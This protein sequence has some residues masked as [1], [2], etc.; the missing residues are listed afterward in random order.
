MLFR[1]Y[2][3]PGLLFAASCLSHASAGDSRAEIVE[4]VGA[5]IK[6]LASDELQGRGVETKGIELAAQHILA[7][8][9][10]FGLKPGMPD[11]TY[12]QKFDITIGELGLSSQCSP[13]SAVRE[14]VRVTKPGGFVVLDDVFGDD[15]TD[16]DATRPP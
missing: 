14:L 16:V 12:R 5:D 2:S 10:K 15:P 7:E 3:L 8:Y 11:G 1:R 4:R 9:E 13:S 6:Y